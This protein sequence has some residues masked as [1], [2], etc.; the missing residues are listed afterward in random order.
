VT[1]GLTRKTILSALAAALLMLGCFTC[2]FVS[3]LHLK[4][5]APSDVRHRYLLQKGDAPDLVRAE[6]LAALRAFQE[7]YLRRDPKELDSFM[8]RL[9]PKDDDILLMG[10]DAEEWARGYSAVGQFIREDWLKWGDF[11]F[12]VDDSIVWSSGDVAWVASV[13]VLHGQRSDRA[14]RFSSI[15]TR[16][17]HN[18]LFRQVHFQWDDRDPRATDLLLPTTHLKLAR[19]IFGYIRKKGRLDP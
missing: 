6:V 13:G 10:T 12:E 9:F 5:G 4:S 2:G 19:S 8:Y 7:G 1:G 14:L 16:S 18:W 17:G 15:L 11:R 3:S